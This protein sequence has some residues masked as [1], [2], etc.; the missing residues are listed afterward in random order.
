MLNPDERERVIAK[1]EKNKTAA[2]KCRV[3]RKEKVQRVRSE[4]EDCVEEN[5]ALEAE[6]RKLREEYQ[7]VRE[8]FDSH[9]CVCTSSSPKSS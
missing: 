1:R 5:E 9:K 6:V 8:L 3:K 2:E 7:I 4:Y